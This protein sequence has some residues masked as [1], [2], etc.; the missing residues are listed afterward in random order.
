MPELFK[1]TS[2]GLF[3]QLPEFILPAGQMVLFLRGAGGLRADQG[4]QTVV[5]L[6]CPLELCIRGMFFDVGSPQV[7][8]GTALKG[9]VGPQHLSLGLFSHPGHQVISSHH[10]RMSLSETA[11]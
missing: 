8:G 9:T 7:T 11:E 5:T 6:H 1:N 4:L 2:V 10:Q 3:Q